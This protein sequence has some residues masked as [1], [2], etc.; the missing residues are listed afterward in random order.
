MVGI[1]VAES[2]EWEVT[3]KYFNKSHEDCEKFPL[4]ENLMLILTLL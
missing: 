3:L 1:S 2:N 4:K